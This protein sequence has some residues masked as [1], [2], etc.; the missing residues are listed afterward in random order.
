MEHPFPTTQR[1]PW[2]SQPFSGYFVR[3]LGPEGVKRT[4][5]SSLLEERDAETEI[6]SPPTLS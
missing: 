3:W 4:P 5:S 2:R 6:P 1:N